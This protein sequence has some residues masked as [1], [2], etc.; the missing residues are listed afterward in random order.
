VERSKARLGLWLLS[1]LL[2]AVIICGSAI[3][4]MGPVGA[5]R[6]TILWNWPVRYD[7]RF[8]DFCYLDFA[9]WQESLAGGHGYLME[10]GRQVFALLDP[11]PL[12]IISIVLV[13]S[14]KVVSR[15]TE[16]SV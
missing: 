4:Y 5:I 15:G 13:V 2:H 11:G 16:W 14:L 3:C 1:A 12:V 8:A 9:I 6:L 7:S 10:D